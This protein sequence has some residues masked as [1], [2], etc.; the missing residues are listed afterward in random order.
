MANHMRAELVVDALNMAIFRR[1]PTG[2]IHHSDDG[3]A[4]YIDRCEDAGVPSM[5][6]VGDLLRQR[7]VRELQCD[8]RA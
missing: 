1:K 2:V 4:V 3:L 5:G 8:S 7:A 6:S